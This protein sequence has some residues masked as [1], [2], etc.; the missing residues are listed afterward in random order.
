MNGTEQ[1]QTKAELKLLL[2]EMMK[3]KE[4]VHFLKPVDWKALKLYTYPR[5][6]TH[7][8]DLNTIKVSAIILQSW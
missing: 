4:A 8:M 1:D 3:K 2:D 6:I 7:P 5:I